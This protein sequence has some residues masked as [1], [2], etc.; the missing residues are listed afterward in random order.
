MSNLLACEV[1][2]PSEALVGVIHLIRAFFPISA[3][4]RGPPSRR[5]VGPTLKFSWPVLLQHDVALPCLVLERA[6]FSQPAFPSLSPF[7]HTMAHPWF[8][9]AQ[10]K[11]TIFFACNVLCLLSFLDRLTSS[12][13]ARLDAKAFAPN[14]RCPDFHLA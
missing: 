9:N 7:M 1:E 11:S 2:G 3:L 14:F 4:P 10:T 5:P 6:R 8:V 12:I 13:F